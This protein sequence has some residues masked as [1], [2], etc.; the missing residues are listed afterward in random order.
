MDGLHDLG[1]VQGFGRVAVEPDE[2]PFHDD[3]ERR[4]FRLTIAAMLSGHLAGRH[5]HAV[6]RID[7]VSYLASSYYERWL[8]GVA[9]VLVEVGVLTQHDLD[10]RLGSPF[11]L[12]SP[13]RAPQLVD[14]GQSSEHPRYVVGDHVRVREWHPLGHT[15]APRYVQG[16]R[17][18]VVRIDGV[19]SVPDVEA[20][21][22]GRRYEPTYSVRF[23]AIELW[24]GSGDPVH[25]DLWE[26][27]LEASDG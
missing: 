20:H 4:T 14:P 12:A 22:D 21:S 5:R 16:K 8:T 24:G 10:E 26:S 17:G 25:A 19:Y 11:G 6:E 27:Y 2:P 1:G 13:V 18:T 7:P 15:R 23:E 9:T 3:I